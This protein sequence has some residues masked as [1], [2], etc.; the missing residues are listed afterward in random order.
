[1]SDEIRARDGGEGRGAAPLRR[2]AALFAWIARHDRAFF[3]T[4]LVVGSCL[5]GFH[6][7]GE[8]VRRGEPNALDRR[9]LLAMRS[10]ENPADPIG[11]IWLEESVRDVSAFGGFGGLCLFTLFATGFLLMLRKRGTALYLLVAVAGGVGASL[12]LKSAYARPRPDLVAHG[13]ALYTKSFPS[14]HSMLS[15]VT[16]L[17]LG[18]LISRA[19]PSLRLKVYVLG[20]AVALTMFVGASR[21]YLG[22]H[23][24]SDVLAGW[25]AGAAWASIVWYVARRLARRGRI[26]PEE[27]PLDGAVDAGRE[28]ASGLAVGRDR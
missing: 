24:P 27:R 16:Y 22:V 12:A 4:V 17:T 23:W 15:A 13:A 10:P 9:I 25:A 18:A 8:Y 6:E 5:Y 28:P 2:S 14:G 26:E 3:L 11:P 1:M 20:C 7:L 19:V 21:V